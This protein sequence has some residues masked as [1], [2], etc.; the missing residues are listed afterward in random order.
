[1]AGY[2]RSGVQAA[3]ANWVCHTLGRF[4]K[5]EAHGDFP[6]STLLPVFSSAGDYSETSCF[7]ATIKDPG[8]QMYWE[9]IEVA[10]E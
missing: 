5:E 8:A 2:A 9:K 3:T 4:R 6:P 1:M 7:L 10:K